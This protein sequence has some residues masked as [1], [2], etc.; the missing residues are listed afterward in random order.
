MYLPAAGRTLTGEWR[1]CQ[2]NTEF[3]V[4]D[5]AVRRYGSTAVVTGVVRQSTQVRGH[6]TSGTFRVGA[7]VVTEPGDPPRLAH[8]QLSGPSVAPD[9]MPGFARPTGEHRG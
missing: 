8:I 3:T 4:G 1:E 5:L 2:V 9:S 6:D 7:V